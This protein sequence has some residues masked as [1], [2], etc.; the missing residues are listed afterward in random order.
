MLDTELK[1][2]LDALQGETKTIF[3][4][5]K[6]KYDTLDAAH[7]ALQCQTDAIDS[8][9]QQRHIAGGETKSLAREIFENAEFKRMG[10]LGG[11]G[12]VTI[13]IE[14]FAK[15]ALTSAAVGAAVSGVLQ[16]D[17][18]PGILPIQYRQLRIRDLLRSKP[19]TLP[20][21]DYVRVSAFVNAAS[22]Q[23]E[24]FAKAESDLSVTSV[25]ARVI[26]L[27]HWTSVP[28]QLFDDLEGL[29][30]MIDNHLVYGLKLK[31]EAELLS[32][33][34]TGEHLNGL[35]PQA[36]AFDT[37]LLG[38]YWNRLDVI[39]RAIQQSEASDY[40]VD[41][42]VLHTNDFWALALT[43]DNEGRYLF[44]DPGAATQPRLW[45]RNVAVTNNITSG[46]FL[47]GSSATALIRDRQDAI[48][49]ISSEHADYWTRNMLAIRCEE[50][51][52]LQVM[53]PG[54]WIYGS[55]S[56]SPATQN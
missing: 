49:E 42:I 5:L 53:R 27:A 34:G 4:D 29:G 20:V 23:V 56:T 12:R 8:R 50:R 24:T 2:A 46:T 17:R 48:V 44:G 28:K 1:S 52:T 16:I 36:T 51:L 35:I 9:G 22:P 31:E 11:R 45:G 33:A 32:G 54:A 18:E 41:T 38:V 39:A 21:C 14:D 13:K 43:K 37:S 30:E 6:T 47:V 10:E 3:T 15:K 7:K 26:T 25:S 19:T 55:F 40:A